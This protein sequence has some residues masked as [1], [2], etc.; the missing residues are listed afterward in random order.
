MSGS[1]G[2]RG[3]I[4][5][6]V[7]IALVIVAGIGA[8][9][10]YREGGL[11]SSGKGDFSAVYD[12][13]D[14]CIS[15]KTMEAVDL[16]GS[17]GGRLYLADYSP[18]SDYAPFSSELNFLGFSVPYWYYVSGNGVVKEN[19]PLIS[20]VQGDIE[21]YLEEGLK[22]CE[23]GAFYEQGISVEL[24]NPDASVKVLDDKVQVQ[25][26]SKMI[27]SK[28][29]QKEVKEKHI[30]EVNSN[31]GA[32]YKEARDIYNYEAGNIFLENYSVDTLRLYAPVDGV[33]IG[34]SPKIWKTR[35]V[36]DELQKGLEANIGAVKLKGD[37]Y[38]SS[39][40]NKYFI[41]NK[42]TDY[43]VN[44][45]YS[46]KWPNKIEIEGAGQEVMVADIVGNQKGMGALGFCYAPY[47]F[48]Y[49]VSFPVM[50]QIYEGN[51]LFQF[52]IVVAID[53]NLPRGRTLPILDIGEEESQICEYPTQDVSISVFDV[54]L[55]PA[56][57]DLS[58]ECFN[59]KC[60]VGRTEGGKYSGKIPSCINGYI[61]ARAEG[62]ADK[63]ILFSSNENN[64]LD[65]VLDREKALDVTLKVGGEEFEGNAIIY[66]ES[67]DKSNTLVMPEMNNITLS[68]GFYNISVY[69]YGNSSVNVPATTSRQCLDVP[70][71]GLQGLFGGVEEQCFD[72]DI[73]ASKIDS[74]LIGG[75]ISSEYILPSD[76]EKG[77][78]VLEVNSLPRPESLEQLQYNYEAFALQGV[79]VSFI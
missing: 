51:E 37:Y 47:H 57:A 67:K 25:V 76:L 56:E 55:N 48:V 58:Y 38:T 1:I 13:Y 31:L 59:Q 3:Q 69:V 23:F 42:N 70:K 43:A 44:F 24:D 72:V 62:Y 6:F 77:K 34:C 68:E 35:E 14:S 63:R 28:D 71:K 61:N 49:D 22:D 52:P 36:V 41:V 17:Q 40:K 30:I 10:I 7:I 16:A 50:I 65:V 79:G 32:L 73:P 78:I 75:G 26:Q 8:Y 60:G 33:E 5:I 46:S 74:A 11:G 27:L 53:N 66:F 9:F 45:L 15:Q 2:K 20:D 4:A 39:D 54:S 29:G 64:Q 12:Y 19:V 21:K 18:G